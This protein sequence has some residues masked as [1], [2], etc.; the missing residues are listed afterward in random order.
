VGGGSAEVI[1]RVNEGCSPPPDLVRVGGPHSAWP[2]AV[3]G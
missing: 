3:V 2:R 1:K